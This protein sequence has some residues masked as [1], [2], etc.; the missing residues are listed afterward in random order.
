MTHG[1]KLGGIYLTHKLEYKPVQIRKGFQKSMKTKDLTTGKTKYFFLAAL[2]SSRSPVV[3]QS[4]CP[5]ICL[6]ETFAKKWHIESQIVT[7]TYLK[8]AYL[9]TY[10]RDSSGGSDSSDTKKSSMIFFV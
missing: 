4:I 5:S 6:S 8:P 2:S 9:P 1:K 10:L 7:K 3:C